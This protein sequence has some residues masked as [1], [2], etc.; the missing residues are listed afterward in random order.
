MS[1]IEIIS[2]TNESYRIYSKVV[3]LIPDIDEKGIRVRYVHNIYHH[4]S[5]AIEDFNKFWFA[6]ELVMDPLIETGV[7]FFDQDAKTQEALMIHELGHY[8]YWKK[9]MNQD[10]LRKIT[11]SNIKL[12]L[13]L[14]E[15]TPS[16][17][18]TH[19]EKILDKKYPSIE[20]LKKWSILWEVQADSK[21]AELGYGKEMLDFLKSAQ[22][23]AMNIKL[24]NKR[25]KFLKRLE[26]LKQELD[27]RINNLEKILGNEKNVLC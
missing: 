1:E 4:A 8:P 2:R 9:N 17:L 13:Y 3:K 27:A 5:I 25:L 24:D 7:L 22:Q 18:P 21:V 12:N 10:R 11:E 15:E 23:R 14:M 6:N 20:T 16:P 19:I 26:F